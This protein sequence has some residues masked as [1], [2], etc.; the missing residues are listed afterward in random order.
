MAKKETTSST[1]ATQAVRPGVALKKKKAQESQKNLLIW[2]LIGLGVL[3]NAVIIYN[4]Y[5]KVQ[6]EL[7]DAGA[8]HFV[9]DF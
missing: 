5:I 9:A 6:Y 2:G 8:G 7:T 1:Q 4:K 3:I